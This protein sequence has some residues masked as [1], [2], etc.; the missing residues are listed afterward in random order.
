MMKV[1]MGRPS[2]FYGLQKMMKTV[3]AVA[4][5]AGPFEPMCGH[6]RLDYTKM[7]HAFWPER[8]VRRVGRVYGDETNHRLCGR[9]WISFQKRYGS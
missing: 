3:H 8:E 5:D 9:C 6:H 7:T 2:Y 4:H 1:M